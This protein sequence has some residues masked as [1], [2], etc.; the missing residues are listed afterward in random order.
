MP[1]RNP[2]TEADLSKAELE[3]IAW[4]FARYGDV[5]SHIATSYL[6]GEMD[7]FAGTNM[8]VEDILADAERRGVSYPELI[9]A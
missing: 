7:H 8:P 3:H 1:K 9:P 5:T 2:R 4:I 6:L